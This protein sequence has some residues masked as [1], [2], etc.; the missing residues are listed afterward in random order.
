MS[1]DDDKLATHASNNKCVVQ[2]DPSGVCVAVFAS[3]LAAA[4]SANS[5]S[6]G[7]IAS[8]CMGHRPRAFGHRWRHVTSDTAPTVGEKMLCTDVGG[9]QRERHR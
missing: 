2:I 4:N 9:R 1:E 7:N 3:L 8:C 6:T 5:D